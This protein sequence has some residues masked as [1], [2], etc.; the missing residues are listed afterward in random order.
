MPKA[1]HGRTIGGDRRNRGRFRY[2]TG[3]SSAKIP[4]RGD[5]IGRPGGPR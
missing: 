4:L 1:R 3:M 5:R 2:E